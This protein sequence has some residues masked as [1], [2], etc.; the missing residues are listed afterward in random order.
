M[1]MAA[2]RKFPT[3]NQNVDETFAEL[4]DYMESIELPG[5]IGN[6]DR[7]TG[8]DIVTDMDRRIEKDIVNVIQKKFPSHDILTEESVYQPT[9]S[10]HL[11]VIDPI[12][13]TVNFSKNYPLYATSVGLMENNTILQGIVYVPPLGKFY[14]ATKNQGAFCNDNPIHTS[15][16]TRLEESLVSIMLTTHY[17]LEETNIA[18][19][20]IQKANMNTRGARVVVSEAAELCLIAEGVLDANVVCIKAD[21]YGAIAGQ[22]ILEEAGGKLTDL[23]GQ[24]FGAA[25]RTI[26]ATNTLLHEELIRLYVAAK[27]EDSASKSGNRIPP[28]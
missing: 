23:S 5:K 1:I 21:R 15:N 6:I 24:P 18:V 16:T 11:W 25:S 12:D 14:S 13:G 17:N 27:S 2:R 28:L 8:R 20:A 19:G 22:L 26:L 4:R 10:R 3:F 9:G 7:K